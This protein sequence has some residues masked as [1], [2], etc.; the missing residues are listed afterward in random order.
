[1]DDEIRNEFNSV[2][3][4]IG[5]LNVDIVDLTERLKTTRRIAFIAYGLAGLGVMCVAVLAK[6]LAVVEKIA[7]QRTA[8]VILSS[9]NRGLRERQ[10]HSDTED[11]QDLDTE[12][13]QEVIAGVEPTSTP[14]AKAVSTPATELGERAKKIVEAD[15]TVH[16][17][18][19]NAV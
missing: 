5:Y 3:Q 17:E 7:H 6:R 4:E 2:G 8:D 16:L 12:D 18:P 14:V 15:T 9:V 19:P 11:E 10:S 13:E 1:M